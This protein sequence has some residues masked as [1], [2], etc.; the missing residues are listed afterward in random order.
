MKE[1]KK[2]H[3]EGERGVQLSDRALAQFGFNTHATQIIIISKWRVI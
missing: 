1:L 2:N 3:K